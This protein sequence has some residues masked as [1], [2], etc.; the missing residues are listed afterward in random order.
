MTSKEMAKLALAGLEDK[1]GADIKVIDISG[2]SVMAD[3][4]LI[5]SGSNRNQV[6]AMADNVEE[7]LH[8]AGVFP[9]QIEGY[10]TANWILM[11]FNDVIVHIF[12]EEDRLFYNL[13]KIW[14]DGKVIDTDCLR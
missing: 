5:A 14:L 7:K 3:Y 2:V 11:D 9:R 6:Q 13:E 4:F 12:N 8:K 1:K 10:Q